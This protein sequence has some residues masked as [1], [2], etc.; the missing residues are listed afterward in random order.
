MTDV[1]FL[2][3]TLTL[4]MQILANNCKS[5]HIST[6]FLASE[7]SDY[8]EREVLSVVIVIVLN[9]KCG[10][11]LVGETRIKARTCKLHCH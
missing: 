6:A 4:S 5:L 9:L 7:A 8:L 1:L 3:S 10:G 2:N 11:N